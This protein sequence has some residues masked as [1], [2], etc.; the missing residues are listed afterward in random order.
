VLAHSCE[1]PAGW[2]SSGFF[3]VAGPKAERAADSKFSLVTDWRPGLVP[4]ILREQ[5]DLGAGLYEHAQTRFTI[6]PAFAPDLDKPGILATVKTWAT[7]YGFKFLQPLVDNPDMSLNDLKPGDTPL[8]Q[9]IVDTLRA[10]L[11]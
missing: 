2:V 7:D 1:K 4:L 5:E 9:Q 10:V 11:Q 3:W 6:G 8:E